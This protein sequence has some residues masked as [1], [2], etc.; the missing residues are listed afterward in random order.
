VR[1]HLSPGRRKR[2]GFRRLQ[3]ESPRSLGAV[4]TRA[5]YE[6]GGPGRELQLVAIASLDRNRRRG[7]RGETRGIDLDARTGRPH[8]ERDAAIV[9]ERAAPV[10]EVEEAAAVLD[11]H[12]ELIARR[13]RADRDECESREADRPRVHP[14]SLA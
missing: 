5:Y 4:R 7:R 10:T 14:R 2:V 12:R 6:R 3:L 11:L 1:V 8:P 9:P 13:A